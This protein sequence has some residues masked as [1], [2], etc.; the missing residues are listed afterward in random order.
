VFAISFYMP[1]YKVNLLFFGPVKL[2]YIAFFT[3]LI[4]IL[5]IPKGNAG[6]HIAHIGGALFGYIYIINYKKGND[7][8]AWMTRFFNL[9][10]FSFK[11]KPKMKVTYNQ[12][13]V[14]DQTWNQS[15]IE[16]QKEIDRILDKIAKGG[17][18]NL[19]KAEKDFLFKTSKE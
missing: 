4:D 18:D 12:R 11:R 2:K 16:K 19:T 3:I 13:P 6:G 8:T 9:F 5:S 15:K 10:K 1:D 7:I 14:D 17:Y